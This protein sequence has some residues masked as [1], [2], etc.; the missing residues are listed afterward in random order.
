MML[1]GLEK[2]LI[3]ATDAATYESS[4]GKKDQPS[5]SRS[6]EQPVVLRGVYPTVN[7]KVRLSYLVRRAAQSCLLRAHT[8]PAWAQGLWVVLLLALV[9]N[10]KKWNNSHWVHLWRHSETHQ[11]GDQCL[12]R[13]FCRSPPSPCYLEPMW[14]AG[15]LR[16]ARIGTNS[17]GS[18]VRSVRSPLP[19]SPSANPLRLILAESRWQ[20]ASPQPVLYCPQP[21]Q[22]E[23]TN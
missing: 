19:A 20:P 21:N 16:G 4:S 11:R 6:N 23:Q 1:K 12:S 7:T 10:R 3:S 5:K 13:T 22:T 18:S 14:G 8:A 17:V 2:P 9:S 15:V